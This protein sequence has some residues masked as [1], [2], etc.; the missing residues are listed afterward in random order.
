M[1]ILEDERPIGSG[2][3]TAIDYQ[4]LSFDEFH[5]GTVVGTFETVA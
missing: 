1:S 2:I 4:R 5:I 3:R